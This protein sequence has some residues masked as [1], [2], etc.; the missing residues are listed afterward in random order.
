MQT[1]ETDAQKAAPPHDAVVQPTSHHEGDS[2]TATVQ[3]T[4]WYAQ[5][6]STQTM[7]SWAKV[8]SS[9][10][11]VPAVFQA[12][13]P[14]SDAP[15]PYTVFVPEDKLG[16]LLKR[17][18]KLICLYDDRVVMLE[19]GPN[20]VTLACYPFHEIVSLE[21]GQILLYSW[22]TLCSKQAGATT[23]TFNT[24]NTDYFDPLIAQVRKAM[25]G[26]ASSA[27]PRLNDQQF[28][29]LS[30]RNFKYMNYGRRSVQSGDAVRMIVY[31][32]DRCV[33]CFRLFNKPIFTRYA[34]SHLSILT[35]QVLILLKESKR[36]K[37][38]KEA[39]YGSVFM[40][41]PLRQIQQITFTTET[42]K[43]RCTM[44]I[45]LADQR[46]LSVEFADDHPDLRA[47]KAEMTRQ[48]LN[49]A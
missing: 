3:D 31:Q 18:A 36:T 14:A 13:L 28:E 38:L 48:Q 24:V 25:T 46:A 47:F 4:Q 19:S 2:M 39:L 26:L 40:Y 45:A 22:L 49:V 42:K 44:Q 12:A 32:P 43:S 20:G 41:L 27:E 11:E 10:H 16:F 34:T 5:T 30:A 17:N 33:R 15:F 29:F 37:S 23:L 1:L 8:I 35:A 21:R 9:Y 7:R 6:S